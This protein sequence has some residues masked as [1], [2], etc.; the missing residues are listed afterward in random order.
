[1]HLL[2]TR[3]KRATLEKKAPGPRPPI[4]PNKPN[5]PKAMVRA[6]YTYEAQD[7]DELSFNENEQIELIREGIN[8]DSD[9]SMTT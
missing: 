6:I 4:Q 9:I 7:T 8:S 1:M 3:E 2:I 5:K